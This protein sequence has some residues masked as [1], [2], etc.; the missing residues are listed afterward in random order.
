MIA[1]ANPPA[2]Q[3]Q[4]GRTVEEL[5]SSVSGS[6]LSTWQ[7]CRLKFFFR[8]VAAIPKRPTA[9]LHLGS[10]VHTVLQRW[11]LARWRET[12]FDLESTFAEAWSTER[13]Q[14]VDWNS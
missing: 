8:Y 3:K 9:A 11:N 2:E 4:V 13:E 7:Q 6:R 1:L 10:T 5:C 12:S 14:T